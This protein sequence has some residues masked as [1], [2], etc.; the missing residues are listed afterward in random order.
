MSHLLSEQSTA[1][2]P[3]N[4]SR[5]WRCWRHRLPVYPAYPH[6][7]QTSPQIPHPGSVTPS[8]W[9]RAAPVAP[10]GPRGQARTAGSS[11]SRERATSGPGAPVDTRS[12]AICTTGFASYSHQSCRGDVLPGPPG[13]QGEQP[14]PNGRIQNTNRARAPFQPFSG[15]N[16]IGAATP[17]RYS[18]L[19]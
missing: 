1:S 2:G 8:G 12:D 6:N 5:D 14:G 10:T 7:L 11:R 19:V 16:A 13:S 4:A 15:L 17:V 9:D 3:G 18:A